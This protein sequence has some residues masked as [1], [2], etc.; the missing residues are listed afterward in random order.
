MCSIEAF[1]YIASHFFISQK[2]K[3]VVFLKKG[4]F[5][6]WGKKGFTGGANLRAGGA[7][8]PPLTMLK[9]AL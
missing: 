3:K 9:E 5:Y 4:H 7:I 2:K 8:A 1:G 6:W